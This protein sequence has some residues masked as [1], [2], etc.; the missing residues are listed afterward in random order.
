MGDMISIEQQKDSIEAYKAMLKAIAEKEAKKLAEEE[1]I[2]R[3]RKEQIK[4]I[5]EYRK[6][7]V[8]LK[9]NWNRIKCRWNVSVREF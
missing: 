5:T 3:K 7:Q 2:A 4:E 6:E 1:A 8:E 9:L